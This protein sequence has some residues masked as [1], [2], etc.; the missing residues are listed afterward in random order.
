MIEAI[1]VGVVD[2][3][4]FPLVAQSMRTLWQHAVRRMIRVAARETRRSERPASARASGGGRRVVGGTERRSDRASADSG[5]STASEEGR[6]KRGASSPE[7]VLPETVKSGAGGT[8]GTGAA[9]GGK[10]KAGAT[11]SSG[12]GTA[13]ASNA[14][15]R[16]RREGKK[17]DGGKKSVTGAKAGNAERRRQSPSRS[18]GRR[19]S[20]APPSSAAAGWR[21][22]RTPRWWGAWRAPGSLNPERCPGHGAM[23]HGGVYYHSGAL[24]G[25]PGM[26]PGAHAHGRAGADAD[27]D[28]QRAAGA[29]VGADERLRVSGMGRT[30]PAACPCTASRRRRR[31]GAS[32]ASRARRR[33]ARRGTPPGRHG[34]GAARTPF[35]A[36]RAGARS[37]V[38]RPRGAPGGCFWFSRR[39]GSRCGCQRGA[40]HSCIP[41]RRPRKRRAVWNQDTT[42]RFRRRRR[43]N[44][45]A[46]G[47]APGSSVSQMSHMSQ[48]A[49][50]RTG[51]G[52]GIPAQGCAA[53]PSSGMDGSGSSRN[54]APLGLGLKR[55]DSL[56]QMVESSGASGRRRR[57]ARRQARRGQSRRFRRLRRVQTGGRRHDGRRHVPRRRDARG[58]RA[59][60][61]LGARERR[62]ACPS[63]GW[64]RRCS[65]RRLG[66]NKASAGREAFD[67]KAPTL[68]RRRLLVR[69]AARS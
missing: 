67:A 44:A 13:N 4:R 42:T 53:I 30:G 6:L 28:H 20:G 65:R 27:D 18:R 61:H 26:A 45:S 35:T 1:R 23:R 55:S 68:K 12:S 7:S 54:G 11:G 19:S 59:G 21:S 56:Q 41:A 36:R 29:G 49:A 25:Q 48:I 24:G 22:S 52:A 46:T 66:P 69:A 51:R 37:D 39:T 47:V 64:T 33:A 15:Q 38:P 60:R 8:G 3:V 9:T 10:R 57:R 14:D 62:P 50:L 32:G 16:K 5:D 34:R 40:H 63:T 58:G 17:E 31:G 2:V 43:R